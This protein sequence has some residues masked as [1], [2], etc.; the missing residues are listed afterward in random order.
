ME[1]KASRVDSPRSSS[2]NS[3]AKRG[4]EAEGQQGQDQR[5]DAE[6]RPPL[7]P[8]DYAR[9]LH[10][11]FSSLSISDIAWAMPSASEAL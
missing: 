10:A 4:L 7:L 6:G 1:A 9:L 2:R 3:K 11:V 5:G 8:L